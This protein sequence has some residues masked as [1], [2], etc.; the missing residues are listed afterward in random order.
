MD[1]MREGKYGYRLELKLSNII[2]FEYS[3]LLLSRDPEKLFLF[4]VSARAILCIHRHSEF[5]GN[6]CLRGFVEICLNLKFG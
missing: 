5:G 3:P 6:F 4:M 1:Q 2:S